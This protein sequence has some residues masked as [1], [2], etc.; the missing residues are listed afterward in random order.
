MERALAELDRSEIEAEWVTGTLA[1]LDDLWDVLTIQNRG[2]LVQAV[3]KRVDVDDINGAVAAELV[4]LSGGDV[5]GLVDGPA[6]DET[7]EARA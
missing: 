4:Y 3:V 5:A 6:T 1:D 2:R 7:T